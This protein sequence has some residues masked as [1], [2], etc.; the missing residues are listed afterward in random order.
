[1]APETCW[2]SVSLGAAA[3]RVAAML[4]QG[5]S[6]G[7]RRVLATGVGETTELRARVPPVPM[8]A[9]CRSAWLSRGDDRS[10][11][12]GDGPV[13]LSFPHPRTGAGARRRWAGRWL[14][15]RCGQVDP[16][17]AG[18]AERDTNWRKGYLVHFRRLVEAGLA[19]KEGAVSVARDGLESLHRRMRVVHADGE[20][21]GLGHACSRHPRTGLL[22]R[23]RCRVPGRPARACRCPTTATDCAATPCCAGWRR[24]WTTA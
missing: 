11:M 4:G 7:A 3:R 18:D 1:M 13:G 2:R 5:R 24:G 8:V 10:A 19:S 23:S 17:G 16:A 6:G 14:L 9:G 12:S 21:T 22:P 20:E 15:M